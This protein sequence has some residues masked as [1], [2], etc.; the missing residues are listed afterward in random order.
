MKKQRAAPEVNINIK[1]IESRLPP[2]LKR[3]H[4]TV[5]KL[6][7]ISKSFMLGERRLQVLHK[8]EL[9]F[10]SGEFV[11]LYGP[12]GC[13]KST[14]LHTVLGLE[15]PTQ[16]QVFLRE[17]NLYE[18]NNDERTAFRREKIGMV[19]Q[20]SNWIK[21][22]K[23]WENVAYPLYLAGYGSSE[24]KTKALNVLAEV[25]MASYA[26]N[27]PTQLSGGQ[28]QRVAL[29]RAIST[30]PWIIICDEPT[31]NLDTI[32]GAE[33]ITLLAKL[34]RQGRRMILMVTHDMSFLP[35]A[36][37]RVAMRDGAIIYDEND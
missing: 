25:E 10:Y 21:S 4:H 13:G 3:S 9:N 16:G 34:N 29:A 1:E 32:A 11:I 22:L 28:Q 35:L 27:M 37:R 26:E 7:N 31:G 15:S 14:F 12:S 30:D 20:Q 18:M 2:K 19:F 24:A 8:I 6:E 36:T 5:I 17:H 23:V 33:I